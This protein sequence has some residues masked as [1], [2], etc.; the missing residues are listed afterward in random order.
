MSDQFSNPEGGFSHA[1]ANC[2]DSLNIMTEVKV[3]FTTDVQTEHSRKEVHILKE[4]LKEIKEKNAR[5]KEI[6]Q[7]LLIHIFIKND[8]DK[9]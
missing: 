8:E 3:N 6:F 5:K 1:A 9:L 4:R 7:M 2:G